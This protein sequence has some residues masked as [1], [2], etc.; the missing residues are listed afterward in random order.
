M[1]AGLMPRP[2]TQE[3]RELWSAVN[4]GN[5]ALTR[6]GSDL[7]TGP[8]ETGQKGGKDDK[9]NWKIITWPDLTGQR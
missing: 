4:D 2:R 8:R 7:S 3:P 9:I 5:P 1:L 6:R